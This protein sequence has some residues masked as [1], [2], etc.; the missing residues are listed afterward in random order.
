[1]TTHIN[2]VTFGNFLNYPKPDPCPTLLAAIVKRGNFHH[3]H[4]ST[5]CYGFLY[6]FEWE[7]SCSAFFASCFLFESREGG[8]D[9]G[10]ESTDDVSKRTNTHTNDDRQTYTRINSKRWKKYFH[11]FIHPWAWAIHPSIHLS[12][13]H[14]HSS[15]G[16]RRIFFI[17]IKSF[18]VRVNV[19]FN[20]QGA[21]KNCNICSSLSLF[22][23]FLSSHINISH[24]CTFLLAFWSE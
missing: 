3:W 6:T 1:M 18:I 8:N 23:S 2:K 17:H 5:F 15:H 13:Y 20:V 11:S 16:W 19:L 12:I 9:G 22:E 10:N 21:A 14:H 24:L 4:D 7:K